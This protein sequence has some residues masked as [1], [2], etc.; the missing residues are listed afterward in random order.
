MAC[1]W[2]SGRPAPEITLQLWAMASM[3]HSSAAA[4]PSG[5]PSSKYARRY[6]WPSHPWVSTAAV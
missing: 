6:H 3:R 1:A 2:R 4:V 5:E